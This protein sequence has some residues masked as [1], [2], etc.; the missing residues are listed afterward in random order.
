MPGSFSTITDTASLIRK[1]FPIT[2]ASACEVERKCR[3]FGCSHEHKLGRHQN[4]SVTARSRQNC[5]QQLASQFAGECIRWL[6][7]QSGV[8]SFARAAPVSFPAQSSRGSLVSPLI[9]LSKVT[10]RR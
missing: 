5:R 1:Q 8:G 9:W 7:A 3:P 4:R 2:N 6:R 10:W